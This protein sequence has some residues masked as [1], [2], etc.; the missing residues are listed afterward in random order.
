MCGGGGGGACDVDSS[1]VSDLKTTDFEHPVN[2][3]GSIRVTLA[4]DPCVRH[5]T[6]SR[7]GNQIHK[8]ESWL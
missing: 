3:G 4:A 1:S 2:L 5:T 7:H 8:G 6:C